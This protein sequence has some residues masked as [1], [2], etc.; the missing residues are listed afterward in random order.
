MLSISEVLWQSH[1]S[2]CP[3]IAFCIISLKIVLIKFLPHLPGSSELTLFINIPNELLQWLH[4][5]IG[6]HT[7]FIQIG[8]QHIK[9]WPK[10]ADILQIT[11]LIHF[12]GFFFIKLLLFCR[13]YFQIHFLVYGK[14]VVC[15]FS[16]HWSLFLRVQ[17]TIIHHWFTSQ[18]C[19]EQVTSC[20][21]NQIWPRSL[22]HICFNPISI[23]WWDLIVYNLLVV[24]SSSQS[25]S[26]N[27][28]WCKIDCEQAIEWR[29]S[30]GAWRY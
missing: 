24:F 6:L 17:L 26:M 20:Y 29:I 2:K 13:Q 23:R 10:M 30:S 8:H 28:Y 1:E 5:C 11:F 3:S 15:W 19:A 25:K 9:V 16:F 14:I 4:K 21:L 22:M 7:G 27:W 18:L 12:L